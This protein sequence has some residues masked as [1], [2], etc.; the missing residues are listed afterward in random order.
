MKEGRSTATLLPLTEGLF[1]AL[2]RPQ[3]GAASIPLLQLL[4]APEDQP[5]PS[6]CWLLSQPFNSHFPASWQFSQY[7]SWFKYPREASSGPLIFLGQAT[8]RVT[9]CLPWAVLLP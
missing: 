7:V 9:G 6:T 8:G 5:A 4:Q 1:S 3:A 2:N